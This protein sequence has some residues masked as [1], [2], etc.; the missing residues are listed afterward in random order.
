MDIKPWELLL[1]TDGPELMETYLNSL[2]RG[3]L[4]APPQNGVLVTHSGTWF[5][6]TASLTVFF[7]L[8][9]F[10]SPYQCASWDHLLNKLIVTCYL[11]PCFGVCFWVFPTKIIKE[12]EIT[13]NDDV[14]TYLRWKHQTQIKKPWGNHCLTWYL[15]WSFLSVLSVCIKSRS[16]HLYRTHHMPYKAMNFKL[17]LHHQ[18]R[19]YTSSW[20]NWGINSYVNL[21]FWRKQNHVSIESDHLFPL[22]HY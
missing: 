8:S 15:A 1:V 11:D 6:N 5:I 9:L 2:P 12:T 7:S 20:R 13:Q 22:F 3:S 21:K 17:N 18:E 4:R 19:K 10:S 14:E 16:F